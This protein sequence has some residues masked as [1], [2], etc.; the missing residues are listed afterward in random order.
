MWKILLNEV[1]FFINISNEILMN[2]K[3]ILVTGGAGYVGSVTVHKLI[4]AGFNVVV[5]DNLSQGSVSG[6]TDS[7]PKSVPFFMSDIGDFEEMDQ[8]FSSHAISCVVH[9]AGYIDVNESVRDPLK[10]FDNNIGRGIVL[11]KVMQKHRCN[12]IIFSSTCAVYGTPQSLPLTESHPTNPINPHGYTKLVMEQMLD[13]MVR[14]HGFDCV[15]LRYFNVCGAYVDDMA[16]PPR[17]CGE[18]HEPETHLIPLAIDAIEKGKSFCVYG[19]DYDTPDG[20][21]VRDYVHVEDIADAHVM[22]VGTAWNGMRTYN[23][24]NENGYSVK[25]IIGL[26]ERVAGKKLDVCLAARR[27]GDPDVLFADSEK[28]RAE[29][30]WSPKHSIEQIVRSAYDWHTIDQK[31]EI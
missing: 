23:L 19:T 28:I 18:D 17:L 30:G 6:H 4:K 15:V 31:R 11:L 27:A 3:N 14:A 13:Q 21:C 24:G 1:D 8:I 26:I 25:E 7:I 29:L 10:Y 20:S 5:V 22:L 2:Q 9:C 12:R 16:D